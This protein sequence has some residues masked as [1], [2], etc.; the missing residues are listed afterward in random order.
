MRT[1]KALALL[2]SLIGIFA[3]KSSTDSK[4]SPSPSGEASSTGSSGIWK[5]M[6]T[7]LAPEGRRFHSAVWTGS[8]LIIFGGVDGDGNTLN[9]GGTY[10]LASDSWTPTS[11]A[12]VQGFDL[13]S[14]IWTGSRMIIWSE[15]IGQSFDPQTNS[16]S[17]ISSTN[18]PS[19]RNQH[20]AIWTGTKMII[21]G[22]VHP[23]TG[24]RL[25]S[26]G[27]YDPISD[28]WE[29]ITLTDA[30]S[31]RY[32]HVAI[33][34]SD[35]MLIF[36]GRNWLNQ[37]L[38]SGAAYNPET[39]TWTAIDN[40]GAPAGALHFGF[41]SETKGLV[42]PGNPISFFDFNQNQWTTVQENQ[43][44]TIQSH[45][46]S[47]YALCGSR[48][49]MFGGMNLG[50]DFPN[51][52]VLF[53]IA[54]EQWTSLPTQSAPSGRRNHSGICAGNSFIVWGGVQDPATTLNTGGIFTP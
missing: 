44:I 33:W 6:S 42:I 11:T 45:T 21:W 13:H 19:T 15:G 43:S 49:F 16:W 54:S 4:A 48:A 2:F 22:G 37:L 41:F 38:R 27:I 28:S 51:Q 18:A 53:D 35:H 30:P 24:N 47:A 32:Q 8:N 40:T 46:D 50:G 3:C 31:A 10:N 29:S 1:L 34:H 25:N 23:S 26:G 39:D 12:G 9:T 14:A 36:G 5:T 17:P 7:V 52:G 20:S